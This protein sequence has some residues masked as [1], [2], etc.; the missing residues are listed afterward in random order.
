VA[1]VPFWFTA[2][3]LVGAAWESVN[4]AA[5]IPV[6]S[7]IQRGG[8]VADLYRRPSIV[9][10]D[11]NPVHAAGGSSGPALTLSRHIHVWEIFVIFVP[12]GARCVNIFDFPRRDKASLWK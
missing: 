10:A 4:F 5:Q 12:R 9:I 11:S 8:V 1:A 7:L 3:W 6:R 2:Y